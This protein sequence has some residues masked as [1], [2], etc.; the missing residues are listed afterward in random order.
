VRK[1]VVS[2][3]PESRNTFE[4][5]VRVVEEIGDRYGRWQDQECLELKDSLLKLE[6]RG[7]G[8]VPLATFYEA[9]LNGQWQFSESK[10]YLR[11]LGS[12][13]EAD[14]GR[15][16]VVIP[17]YVNSP[18]NCVASS[19]F[20]S[21]CCI[22]ECEALLGHLERTMT[23]PTAT[24]TRIV[25]VIETLPSA[26]V[27]APRKL[28]ERLVTRLQE[29]ATH[30]GGH[31]PFHARL[32]NQWLHHAYP[33]ECPYPHV[34]GTSKPIS[35][36]RWMEQT[37]ENVEADADT[38]R[39]HVEE[40]KRSGQPDEFSEELPWSGEEEFFIAHTPV[41]S[42]SPGLSTAKMVHRGVAF[43]A[44]LSAAVVMFLRLISTA[45]E[46]MAAGPQSKVFV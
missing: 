32:F 22:N 11:Q 43:I 35:P 30:H 9:A 37:G 44:M 13:D 3:R 21:V 20:Y 5:M 39:W 25:E 4:T 14:E 34:S 19:K 10:S 1:E 45:K 6:E 28:P 27:E 18:T 2:S 46:G 41:E 38:M 16:A 31:V 42:P 12:L 33:R 15:P 24:P 23:A 17:N 26:T 29:I 36:E 8:R 40:G 7:T